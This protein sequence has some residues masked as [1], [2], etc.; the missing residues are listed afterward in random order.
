[1]KGQLISGLHSRRHGGDGLR[2]VIFHLDFGDRDYPF[3]FWRKQGAWG[4]E[5]YG[6]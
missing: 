2:I 4:K 3:V 1:M 5:E 6:G